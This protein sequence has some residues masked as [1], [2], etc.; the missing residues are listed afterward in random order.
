MDLRGKF[1]LFEIGV[2]ETGFPIR[3]WVWRSREGLLWAEVPCEG[4]LRY[5]EKNCPVPGAG[6]HRGFDQLSFLLQFFG[7]V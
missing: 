6:S 1:R 3:E 5:R 4:C 2:M 7:G